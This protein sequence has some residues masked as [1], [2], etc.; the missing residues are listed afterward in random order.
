[1]LNYRSARYDI[2]HLMTTSAEVTEHARREA[3]ATYASQWKQLIRWYTWNT[4]DKT[5]VFH[6][7]MDATDGL[8]GEYDPGQL[9]THA[10]EYEANARTTG[11]IS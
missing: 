2:E 5:W 10:L 6:S 4:H 11:G 7:P 9:I 8:V 3:I 1:M